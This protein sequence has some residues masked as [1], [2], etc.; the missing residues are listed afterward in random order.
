MAVCVCVC[1]SR[2]SQHTQPSAGSRKESEQTLV[3]ST[4]AVLDKL[5]VC[6]LAAIC[7]QNSPQVALESTHCQLDMRP[8]SHLAAA[9][10]CKAHSATSQRA[11]GR[12]SRACWVAVGATTSSA[13]SRLRA[14]LGPRCACTVLCFCVSC[15]S[16]S[17]GSQCARATQQLHTL[18]ERCSTACRAIDAGW[19]SALVADPCS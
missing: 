7:I 17:G 6:M 12:C 13:S 4:T 8:T 9:R 3:S 15:M 18:S 19:I 14:S 1:V 10:R 11:S 5:P 2:L 16:A